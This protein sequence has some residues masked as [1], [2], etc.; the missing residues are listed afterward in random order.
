MGEAVGYTCMIGCN[1]MLHFKPRY[2]LPNLLYLLAGCSQ[3]YLATMSKIAWQQHPLCLNPAAQARTLTPHN[4][5]AL[6]GN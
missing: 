1:D 6:S 2:C 3:A 4:L 5:G